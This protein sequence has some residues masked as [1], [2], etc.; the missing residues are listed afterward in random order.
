MIASD[1]VREIREMLAAG[2]LSQRAIAERTGVS[3]GTVS[4]I[5]QGKRPDYQ[6]RNHSTEFG[7]IPPVGRPAR[8][9]GCGGL[10]L[11]PCL[12]CY[13]RRWKIGRQIIFPAAAKKRNGSKTR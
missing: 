13:L 8:C 11:M 7:F 1:L 2:G 4:A 10:V 12:A 6:P 9:P 5:A 3:R